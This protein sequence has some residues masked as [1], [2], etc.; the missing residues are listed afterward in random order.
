MT[1]AF[2]ASLPVMTG[3][4]VLGLGFGILLSTKGYNALFALLMSLVIYS[5]TMQFVAIDL[6]TSGASLAATGMT[7]LMVSARHLFY[8]LSM[9]ERYEKVSGLRK[10]YM[11]FALTDETYSLVCESDDENYC[12]WVSLLNHIYWTSGSIMGALL[13]RVLPFDS[14]GIDFALTA[15]FVSI[16]VEQWLNNSNHYPAI[17]GFIVS[18]LCLALFGAGNFLIPSMLLITIALFILRERIE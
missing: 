11:I 16:C 8:G 17:T 7:S 15:L 10:I 1:S 3:Y 13:G 9:I 2:R 18:V 5:G 4:V 12:F 6:F 14:R